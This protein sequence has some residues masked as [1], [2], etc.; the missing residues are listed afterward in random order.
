MKWSSILS[1]LATFFAVFFTTKEI[2]LSILLGI[3]IF[4]I[5][6]ISWSVVIGGK[7]AEWKRENKRKEAELEDDTKKREKIIENRKK[8]AY[9]NFTH[10][11]IGSSPVFTCK[12]C[13]KKFKMT[14]SIVF[15]ADIPDIKNKILNA[16][17]FEHTCPSCGNTQ[18]IAYPCVYIDNNKKFVV[19]LAGPVGTDEEI[20]SSISVRPGFIQ[21]AVRTPVDFIEKIAIFDQGYSDMVI[22]ALK[23]DFINEMIKG[24]GHEVLSMTFVPLEMQDDPTDTSTIQFDIVADPPLKHNAT[25]LPMEQFERY[26]KRVLRY[27]F[28]DIMKGEARFID[29]NWARSEKGLQF[30]RTMKQS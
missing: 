15:N 5:V 6:S 13:E 8:Y 9:E 12:N 3:I 14:N 17:I 23:L 27:V 24:T 16:D 21:R 20:L 30:L 29:E 2:G 26:G 11:Y 7:F 25:A 1:G 19:T 10:T 28:E 4:L 22:E 18:M